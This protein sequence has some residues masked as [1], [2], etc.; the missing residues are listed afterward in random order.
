MRGAD[1]LLHGVERDHR[2]ADG[3]GIGRLAFDRVVK[4]PLRVAL[5]VE[6]CFVGVVEVAARGVPRRFLVGG[7]IENRVEPVAVRL[8]ECCGGEKCE[9]ENDSFHAHNVALGS[10]ADFTAAK[11]VCKERKT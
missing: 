3:A 2:R 10:R 1:L 5:F 6:E 11:R 9:D 4:R 8:R 7:E